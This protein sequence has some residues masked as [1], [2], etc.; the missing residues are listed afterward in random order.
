MR[1]DVFADLDR[2]WERFARSR[3]GAAALHR[4]RQAEPLFEDFHSLCELVSAARGRPKMPEPERVERDRLMFA[5]VGV[6]RADIDA[7]QAVLWV[8]R[9]GLT[10]VAKSYDHRWSE[11][12]AA[13][14]MLA[15]LERI[16]RCPYTEAPNIA[17]NLVADVRHSLWLARRRELTREAIDATIP[18]TAASELPS[19]HE[20]DPT[21]EL[22]AVVD[23]AA[24]RGAISSRGRALILAHRVLDVPT[25][26]IAA[27]EGRTPSTVRQYRTRA[28]ATLVSIGRDVA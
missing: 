9:P 14:V 13:M 23:A 6:G 20:T 15:A 27:S 18:L 8:L 12:A 26:D 11:D 5:L 16:A 1:S 2:A 21:A 4:W 7:R 22:V 19:V 24:K 10:L 28:E 17:A 3:D 25:R